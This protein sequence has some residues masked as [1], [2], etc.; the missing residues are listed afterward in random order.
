PWMAMGMV[1]LLAASLL[2]AAVGAVAAV[3]WS[4]SGDPGP[5]QAL[6]AGREALH[7]QDFDAA[8]AAF[9]EAATQAPEDVDVAAALAYAHLLKGQLDEADAELARALD[10]ASPAQQPALHLRR[11][12]VA[13]RRG[14]LDGVQR[15]GVRSDIPAGLVMAAEVHLADAESDVAVPLLQRAASGDDVIVADTAKRYLTY[16]SDSESGRAQLAEAVAMW[17]LG[18]RQES[19]ESSYELLL[20]VPERTPGRDAELLLW[21]GRAVVSGQPVIAEDLLDS[22]TSPP[23]GH[24]WRVQATRA[25]VSVA[26]GRVQDA[27]E[28]FEMLEQAGAPLDG[29]AD[30]RLTAASLVQDSGVRG[31]LL[32]DLRGPA[33]ALLLD[34]PSRLEE[35]DTAL[36]AYL[37]DR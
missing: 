4:L 25:M 12:L 32:A 35:R 20:F 6:A 21:A 31:Q 27:L 26:D 13:Q 34:D 15:H 11:A 14:D 16:L 23:P 7:A 30:A 1:T 9:E 3:A 19:V 2:V 36:A 33:A 37:R 5:P 24:A 18:Q 28:H 10:V 22:M 17:A 29:L 8:F